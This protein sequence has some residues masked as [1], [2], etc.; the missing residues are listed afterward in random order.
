MIKWPILLIA[1]ILLILSLNIAT[2]IDNEFFFPGFGN[3]QLYNPLTQPADLQINNFFSIYQEITGTSTQVTG[4]GGGFYK[5]DYEV[6]IALKENKIALGEN[7][8]AKITITNQHNTK[9]GKILITYT[10]T[11]KY[12][13]YHKVSET[14]ETITTLPYKTSYPQECTIYGGTYNVSTNV[15]SLVL[16]RQIHIPNKTAYIGNWTFNLGY[17]VRA[18][19]YS[20]YVLQHDFEVLEYINRSINMSNLNKLKNITADL[21][22]ILEEEN[23]AK[24]KEFFKLLIDRIKYYY[25]KA[26]TYLQEEL[27]K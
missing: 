16:L 20:T 6:K 27:Q 24:I 21:D 15:C 23:F 11:P 5:P 10:A 4:G 1:I 18:N 2:A 26:Y 17:N 13:R 8:T 14:V 22:N 12:Q 9:A 7:I 25:N 19:I 3:D